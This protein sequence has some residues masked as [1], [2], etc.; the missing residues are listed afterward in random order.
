MKNIEIADV[1]IAAKAKRGAEKGKVTTMS[2]S[3]LISIFSAR[4]QQEQNEG[5]CSTTAMAF[6][7]SYGLTKDAREFTGYE[8]PE[9]LNLEEY[10]AA[11]DEWTNRERATRDGIAMKA[12]K[13]LAA[14]KALN[15]FAAPEAVGAFLAS[16]TD[17]EIREYVLEKLNEA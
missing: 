6:L 17:L 8:I 5:K 15:E 2:L 12:A 4:V 9:E 10:E 11:Y 3:D 7:F 14:A 1:T 16:I 13:P